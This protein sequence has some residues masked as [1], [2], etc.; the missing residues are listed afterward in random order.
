MAKTETFKVSTSGQMSLPAAVRHRWQLDD[1]GFVEVID[2]GFGVLTVPVGEAGRLLD[3]V[4]PAEDHYAAV[5]AE[6]DPDLVS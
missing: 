3:R 1:G 5:A 6:D 2:L 4:V